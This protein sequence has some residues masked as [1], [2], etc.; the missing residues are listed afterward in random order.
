MS[1]LRS[2]LAVPFTTTAETFTVQ[3][4]STGSSYTAT[5]A[6]G[7]YR[8]NLAPSASDALR[9]LAAALNA[10]PG[11]PGGVVFAATI[12][13]T[14]GLVSVTCNATFK[15]GTLHST[16]LGKVLGYTTP[17]GAYALVE[18]ATRQPWYCA[19]FAGLYG[20][21]WTPRRSGAR[22][23]TAG[24]VVNSFAG[25]LTSYDRELTAEVVPWDPSVVT[26]ESLTTTPFYPSPEYLGDVAGIG[27][28]TRVWGLVDVWAAAQNGACALAIGDWQT[29]RTSTTARY[30]LGYLANDVPENVNRQDEKWQA[31]LTLGFGFVLPTTGATGTRA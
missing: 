19:F 3:M 1:D 14:T 24:G 25:T 2:M 4:Q 9:V 28:A 22:E 27:T 26:A 17:M 21:Q 16:L 20:G 29:Q 31:F 15:L 18:T 8:V 11:L 23:R 10:A 30:F 13:A 5:I 7:T 6:A 12:D